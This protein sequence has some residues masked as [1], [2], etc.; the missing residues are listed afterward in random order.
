MSRGLDSF[1]YTL[2]CQM[3]TD[4]LRGVEEGKRMERDRI[5]QELLSRQ[6]VIAFLCEANDHSWYDDTEYDDARA[7]IEAA[8]ASIGLTDHGVTEA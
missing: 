3:Q 4:Y 5:R 8:L 6:S 7:T 2:S 1:F